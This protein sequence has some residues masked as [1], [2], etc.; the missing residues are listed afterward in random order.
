MPAFWQTAHFWEGAGSFG[1]FVVVFLRW[2][3]PPLRRRVS[4]WHSWNVAR[5]GRPGDDTR[6]AVEPIA[7]R[8]KNVERRISEQSVII[9]RL[10]H[11]QAAIINRQ[12]DQTDI[13]NIH[14]SAL[15]TLSTKIDRLLPNG[16][17]TNEPG[18]LTMRTAKAVGAYL[19]D[20]DKD[21][22]SEPPTTS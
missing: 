5:D 10:D 22:S 21:K 8:M 18:D 11:G 1:A 15:A 14:T 3:W 2:V 17:N 16:G 12:D 20:L 19:T 6:P 4:R 7:R 13:M 9:E